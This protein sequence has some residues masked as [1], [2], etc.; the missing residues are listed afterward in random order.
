[1]KDLIGA[2]T[3]AITIGEGGGLPVEIFHLK[4][5]WQPGWGTLRK[6]AGETIDR[7]RARGVDVAADMYVY[8]AGGTGLE[9]SIPT[10]VQEGGRAAFVKR[11]EDPEVR[12]R[13]KGEI[14]SGAPGWSN[15]V[16]AA[17]GWDHVVLANARSAE[18][19]KLERKRP[20]AIA[21]E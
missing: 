11:L 6:R 8:T 3:E 5:A 18:N 20:P 19:Q 10:W 7:A 14:V 4:A 2:I 17:G 15:L 16:E 21:Q 9:A 13:L 12:T 1:G